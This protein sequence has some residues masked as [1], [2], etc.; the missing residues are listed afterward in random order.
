MFFIVLKG[1][2]VIVCVS[3]RFIG[4]VVDYCVFYCVSFVLIGLM[5]FFVGYIL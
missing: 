5:W 3:N 4:V 2:Y 1:L